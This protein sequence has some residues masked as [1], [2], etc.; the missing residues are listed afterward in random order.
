MSAENRREL[1][2]ILHGIGMSRLRMAYLEFGLKRASYKTLNLGYPSLRNSI[3]DC[4]T[5]I[6]RKLDGAIADDI[7]KIHFVGHSMG[8]LVGLQALGLTNL[9]KLS[10]AVLIAPPFRGSEVADYLHRS[11][12]Y[13]F[14]FGPAGGQLTTHYR[15]DLNHALPEGLEV[16]VI[17]GSRGYEYPLFLHVMKKTGVHDGLVALSST[18]IDGLKDHITIR[19]SHSFLLERSVSQVTYFLKNGSFLQEI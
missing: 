12:L 14:A 16:G 19:M 11:A 15:R 6:A 9:P 5:F 18:Q 1:V 13:K 2:V 10:R 17:A 7:E 3:E 8:C 4:A